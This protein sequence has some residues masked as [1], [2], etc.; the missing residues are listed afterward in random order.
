VQANDS[1]LVR[2]AKMAVASRAKMTV[3]AARVIDNAALRAMGGHV[4]ISTSEGAP[5]PTGSASQNYPSDPTSSPAAA[6]ATRAQ[7]QQR[8][9]NLRREQGIMAEEADQPYGGLYNEDLVNRRLAETTQQLNQL[10][11]QPQTLNSP[12]AGGLPQ[13]PVSSPTPYRPPQ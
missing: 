8:I 2:A 13:M 7:I 10:G 9:N 6:A 3:H 1:L 11:A 12:Q 5:I 4:A